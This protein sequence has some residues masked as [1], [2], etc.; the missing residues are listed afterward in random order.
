MRR[1]RS[2]ISVTISGLTKNQSLKNWA[3]DIIKKEEQQ[4]EHLINNR[5]KNL[6]I[7]GIRRFSNL[8][9]EIDNL[10][11]FTIGQP[12]F[13]TPSHVKQAGILAIEH[14]FT[15]YTHNAGALELR[16]AACEF[17]KKKY[18]LDYKPESEV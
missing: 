4:M 18:Q 7:S 16:K 11:S 5:V 15:S 8:V 13:P 9:S 12:D 2:P 10:I 6:E 1:K 3:N 14:N 17:V